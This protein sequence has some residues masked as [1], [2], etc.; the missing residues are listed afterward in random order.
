MSVV[1]TDNESVSCHMLMSLGNKSYRG[2]IYKQF[3]DIA[4]LPYIIQ[5]LLI[6]MGD[7]M[8]KVREKT[9]TSKSGFFLMK[10]ER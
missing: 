6:C 7:S 2:M 10:C 9:S 5:I 1:Q 8:S 4:V 3:P